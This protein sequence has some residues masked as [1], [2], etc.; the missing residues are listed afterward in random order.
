MIKRA[1][2]HEITRIEE[3]KHVLR[4]IEVKRVKAKKLEEMRENQDQSAIQS[5]NKSGMYGSPTRT[6]GV[7]FYDRS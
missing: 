4:E 1:L 2:V 6:G 5:T 3:R 7:G